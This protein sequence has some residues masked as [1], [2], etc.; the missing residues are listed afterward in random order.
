MTENMTACPECGADFETVAQQKELPLQ[1]LEQEC[2]DCG[3][4]VVVGIVNYPDKTY[5]VI[6]PS[7]DEDEACDASVH[8]DGAFGVEDCGD[9]PTHRVQKI[10]EPVECYCIDHI[11]AHRQA[12]FDLSDD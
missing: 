8:S 4:E 12:P 10:G 11:G 2:P 3:Y 5:E 9:P 6:A 7:I 1:R